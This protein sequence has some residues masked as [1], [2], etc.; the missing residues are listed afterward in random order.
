MSA[1]KRDPFLL[2]W[3]TDQ[4]GQFVGIGRQVEVLFL[5]GLGVPDVFVILRH[6]P[7]VG[8]LPVGVL[9]V[10]PGPLCFLRFSGERQETLAV[11]RGRDFSSCDVK[12]R[13]HDVPELRDGVAH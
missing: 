12:E 9:P 2:L 1:E 7:V 8:E 10:E 3:L 5:T 6:D 11:D 13:R 4:V